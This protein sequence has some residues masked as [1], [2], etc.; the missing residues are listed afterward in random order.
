MSHWSDRLRNS[1]F[2][3]RE[4]SYGRR[5]ARPRSVWF[6]LGT[7]CV[8]SLLLV[9]GVLVP[10]LALIG[11]AAGAAWFV[12]LGIGTITVVTIAGCLLTAGLLALI[13]R[14]RNGPVAWILAVAAVVAA[15]IISVYPVFAVIGAGSEAVGQLLPTVSAWVEQ[16]FGG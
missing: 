10:L 7:G 15:T 16:G 12:N 11:T 8:V 14:V 2:G 4:R 13:L 9:V 5:P 1:S 6:A 3:A